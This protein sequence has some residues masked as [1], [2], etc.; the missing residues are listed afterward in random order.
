M[1]TSQYIRRFQQRFAPSDYAGVQWGYGMACESYVWGLEFSDLRAQILLAIALSAN[2][3]DIL[4]R[5]KPRRRV[6]PSSIAKCC[7]TKGEQ[8][9]HWSARLHEQSYAKRMGVKEF[10]R[11]LGKSNQ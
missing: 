2:S 4:S 8:I 10:L 5:P 9:R 3:Q 1:F 11:T 7:L 6:G